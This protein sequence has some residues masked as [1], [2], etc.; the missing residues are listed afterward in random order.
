MLYFCFQDITG[1]STEIVSNYFIVSF[2]IKYKFSALN[3][4]KFEFYITFKRPFYNSI[5]F[6]FLLRVISFRS[7][8]ISI[9]FDRP[10]SKLFTLLH[11]LL[12]KLSVV[13]KYPFAL[14]GDSGALTF[15][16]QPLQ[17]DLCVMQSP[18]VSPIYLFCS[19]IIR[20]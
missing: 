9:F 6:Y 16:Q 8:D 2:F 12:V 17:V 20:Q 18:T 15:Y 10:I 13:G 14:T 4:Y 19:I 11:P 7:W 3:S 1:F 5:F